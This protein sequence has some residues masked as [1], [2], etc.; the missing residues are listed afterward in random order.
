MSWRTLAPMRLAVLLA[1]MLSLLRF[2][3]CLYLHLMDVR[4]MDYRF[5]ERG[6]IRPGPEVA[7]VAIDDP[8]VATVGRWPWSRAI[9]AHLVDRV[10]AGQP[11]V[12]G[13]DITFSESS[14]FPEGDGISPRPAGV[15]D[16][17]WAEV[18][19]A[20]RAQDDMLV[21]SLRDSGRAVLGAFFVFG[22]K[23]GGPQAPAAGAA[24]SV[25]TY[26]LVL[27]SGGEEGR[28]RVKEA[29]ALRGNLPDYTAAAREIGYFNILPDDTDGVIRRMPLVVRY[30]KRMTLP[31]SLAILRV[32]RPDRPLAVQLRDYGVDAVRFGSETV[33]V[34]E[35]GQMLINYRG[36][37]RTFPHYSAI[38][39]LRGKVAP[40]TF[41]NKIVL[42]GVT[43][44]AVYDIRVTPFDDLFP[45]VEMHANVIDNILRGDFVRRP[46][47]LVLAD[48]AVIIAATLLL[49]VALRHSRGVNAALVAVAAAFAYL[50]GS[51]WLF[52]RHGIPLSVIYPLLAVA[53]TYTG[54]SVQH[55]MTEEREKRK[56][57]KALE[58][59]LSPSMA[60]LVSEHPE[61]LKLGGDKRELTVF[62]SDI[63]GFTTIAERLAPEDLVELLNQY[64]GAM[65]D[66]VFAHD[67][68]LDKYIG[69]AVM[70]V[71]G[72]P[73]PQAD[74]ARR[75]CVA[76]LQMVAK[77]E[78]LNQSWAPRGWPPL[79]IGIGLN[80][81]PMVFGNMG[82]AQH[83]SL[84]VMGDNVNLG[85]RLEGLNKMYGTHIIVSE[86]CLQEAADAVVAR[87]LDLV[88][89][90][91]KYEP[92]RIFELLALAEDREPWSRLLE[93]FNAGLAAYRQRRWDEAVAHLSAVLEER[94]G[95]GPAALYLAR[96]RTLADS[97]PPV[98]WDGVTVMES[99]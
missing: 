52:T 29:A 41:R 46:R 20:L 45:G 71:W 44:T 5:I 59:Y 63:R 81:G 86:A 82:S 3:G 88:R 21:G 65:T 74:H 94:P 76:S 91:G 39:I 22:K 35:D 42:F 53:L 56:V 70:A 26:N 43:A 2:H 25:S 54:I 34:A 12:M 4:A 77:L 50:V 97:P 68:M 73:L 83:L 99:K 24:D 62:F 19:R 61:E 84:T 57:R 67:G 28:A 7:I 32:Y 89:V 11:A 66:I 72:A 18:Q 1:I 10:S 31:L 95:D 69:D 30:D 23:A 64:L 87:E 79:E 6:P 90:K 80:S 8:S 15:D 93:H 58:L 33:P 98:D 40:E 38:D 48:L 51:Q 13:F 47:V 60:A 96:C 75:A 92:V 17:T 85:S 14:E 16:R 9:L 55:F 37:G 36:P 78:H 27:G 49:G